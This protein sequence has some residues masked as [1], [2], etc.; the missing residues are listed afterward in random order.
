MMF[1]CSCLAQAKDASAFYQVDLIVFTYNQVTSLAT[2]LP[3]S[4]TL[5]TNDS[6]AIPLQIKTNNNI[7]PYHLLPS[8]FSQLRQEYGALHRKPQYHIL[9]HYTWLQPRN[10]QLPIALPKINHGGWQ[11]EGTLRIRRANYYLLDAELLFSPNDNQP[12]FVLAQKQRLK[13]GMIY[14]LD[15]PQ[16]GVLIKVHKERARNNFR[17]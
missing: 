7:T 2:E 17:N 15:H 12:P 1:H 14:Y 4:S 5:S 13:E 16:A 6:H 10:N 3:L 11:V 9:L 8:S